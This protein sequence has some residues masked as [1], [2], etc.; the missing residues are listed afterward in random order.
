M[1][2]VK[3][4]IPLQLPTMLVTVFMTWLIYRR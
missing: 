4:G 2:F 3:V 1:G